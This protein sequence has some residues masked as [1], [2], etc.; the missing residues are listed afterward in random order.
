MISLRQNARYAPNNLTLA[1]W[2]SRKKT[3]THARSHAKTRTPARAHTQTQTHAHTQNRY[4]RVCARL[5]TIKL[6]LLTR[7]LLGNLAVTVLSETFPTEYR[8]ERFTALT[9]FKHFTPVD[10]TLKQF[11]QNH[12]LIKYFFKIHININLHLRLGL[13][14]GLLPFRYSDQNLKRISHLS[15]SY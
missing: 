2:L 14:G 13:T 10:T 6:S 5:T 3:H 7:V 8:L 15:H 11:N 1:Q 9:N 12:T 4:A